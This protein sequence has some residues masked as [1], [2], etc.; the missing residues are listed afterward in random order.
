MDDDPDLR[1]LICDDFLH[2][3]ADV[4]AASNGNEAIVLITQNNYDFI[5]SDMRMPNGDGCYLAIEVLK[6][7]GPK[8]LFFL[9]SGFNDLT[10]NDLIKLGV[11]EVF[12]KPFTAS[13]MIDSILTK[14]KDRIA[15]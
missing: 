15:A 3:G 9:Y 6:L 11:A 8:P 4:A 13:D 14:F 7:S 1:E 2:A 10:E 5:I 12:T